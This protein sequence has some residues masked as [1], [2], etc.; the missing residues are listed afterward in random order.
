MKTKKKRH[1]PKERADKFVPTYFF[2]YGSLMQAYGINGRQMLKHYKAEDIIPCGLDGY[3]R[4]MCAYFGSRIFYGL[5]K[6]KSASCNGIVFKVN[7]WYDYRV[8]LQSEGATAAFRDLR[9]YW[10]INVTKQITGWDI[11]KDSRV[12]TLLCKEDKSRIGRAEPSYIR[13]CHEAAV[14][15]GETFEKR[16][17]ASGGIPYDRKR[18][19]LTE[20]A[21]QHNINIW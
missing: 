21:K 6:D 1:T 5:M 17:L 4:S 3:Q 18:R 9:T 7:S 15:L 10:P 13:I 12:I 14:M 2:G 11:P 19:N 16:F 20:I 8:L